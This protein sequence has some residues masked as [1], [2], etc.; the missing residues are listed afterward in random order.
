MPSRISGPMCL[1][2]QLVTL[3]RTVATQGEAACST[4]HPQ[5]RCAGLRMPVVL[6][7][8]GLQKVSLK[9]IN[10]CLLSP[11]SRCGSFGLLITLTPDPRS[12]RSPAHSRGFVS[13]RGNAPHV[14]AIARR[15]CEIVGTPVR[16][17]PRGATTAQFAAD[18]VQVIAPRFAKSRQ[19][20]AASRAR[21]HWSHRGWGMSLPEQPQWWLRLQVNSPPRERWQRLAKQPKIASMCM[22]VVTRNR[23]NSGT[24]S[25]ISCAPQ[26]GSA[27]Q[28]VAVPSHHQPAGS[29]TQCQH[30]PCPS[31]PQQ[32][33]PL[34]LLCAM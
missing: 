19:V 6:R 30:T 22:E 8:H 18:A 14:F 12:P 31:Q 25:S 4:H 13:A 34:V 11:R 10:S 21:R 5:D 17:W 29:R 9:S 23:K 24:Q 15:T 27:L 33:S 3:M 32:F 28:I 1:L 20:P 7:Y 16:L 2:K 26:T